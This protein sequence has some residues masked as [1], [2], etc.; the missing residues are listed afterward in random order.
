MRRT[1]LCTAFL[2]LVAAVSGFAQAPAESVQKQV[3]RPEGVAITLPF[4]PG[5]VAGD[6][7]FVAGQ[8]TRDSKSGQRPAPWEDQARQ[9]MENVRVVLKTGGMDL[10]NVVSCH[11]YGVPRP[12]ASARDGSQR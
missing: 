3:F 7:V 9:S 8:G 10:A 6:L 2:A 5:I 4:S 11:A 1:L 12:A